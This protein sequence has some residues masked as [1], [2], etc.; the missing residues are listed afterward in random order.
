MYGEALLYSGLRP[1]LLFRVGIN[2]ILGLT[3]AF[4]WVWALELGFGLG[5]GLTL[6]LRLGLGLALSL[7][8]SLALGLSSGLS[9]GLSLGWASAQSRQGHGG[10]SP[11]PPWRSSPPLCSTLAGALI[12]WKME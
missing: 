3:L 11:S 12:T 7:A 5:L 4:S 1:R 8:L 10:T 2:F 6:G 9:S